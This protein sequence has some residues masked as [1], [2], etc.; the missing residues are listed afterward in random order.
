VSIA[1][2]EAPRYSFF[3]SLF[4]PSFWLVRITYSP[5]HIFFFILP[6][7]LFL[8]YSKRFHARKRQ[9]VDLN[10]SPVRLFS[11]FTFPDSRR[12]DMG[13]WTQWQK[14][15]NHLYLHA[16]H[17]PGCCYSHCNRFEIL[18]GRCLQRNWR[19]VLFGFPLSWP[20]NSPLRYCTANTELAFVAVLKQ[21]IKER[22]NTFIFFVYLFIFYLTMLS[23]AQT[24]QQ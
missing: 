19:L 16:L 13:F 22:T 14:V 23:V 11:S 7:F 4:L 5:R 18:V 3:C 10:L 8:P 1:I 6:Q 15:L 9:Q 12:E 24:A 17:A 21:S 20:A 2:Y